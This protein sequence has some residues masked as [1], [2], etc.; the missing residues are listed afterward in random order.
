V[1][2]NAAAAAPYRTAITA[3]PNVVDC[4]SHGER[5]RIAVRDHDDAAALIAE[6]T[7]HAAPA[8]ADRV[9][10]EDAFVAM[11]EQPPA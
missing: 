5:L 10:V 1:T 6:L 8:Q 7:E 9:T 11:M 4:A 3:H 2:L